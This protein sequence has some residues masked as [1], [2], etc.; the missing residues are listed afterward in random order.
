MS[1]Q[2]NYISAIDCKAIKVLNVACFISLFC[3]NSLTLIRRQR[4][5]FYLAHNLE[6]KKKKNWLWEFNHTL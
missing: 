5:L 1:S 3:W 4:T 2:G 6:K